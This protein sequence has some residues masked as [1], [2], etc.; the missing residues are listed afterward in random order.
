MYD[1]LLIVKRILPSL[2]IALFCTCSNTGP[3]R[4]LAVRG[5]IDLMQWDFSRSGSVDLRGEWE[6][7]WMRLLPPEDFT[8]TG[9]ADNPVYA[10]V[11]R[12]W[13]PGWK[14]YF[15]SYGR[16]YATYRLRIAVGDNLANE[17]GMLIERIPTACQLYVNSMLLFESGRVGTS[18][19]SVVPRYTESVVPLPR[20]DGIYDIVVHV[21]NYHAPA[22]GFPARIEIGKLSFLQKSLQT[23][24]LLSV[25]IVSVI[26]LLALYQVILFSFQRTELHYLYFTLICMCMIIYIIGLHCPFWGSVI[27]FL[28]WELVY[29]GMA[30]AVYLGCAL[31]VAYLQRLFPLD[32]PR[33]AVPLV[34]A[35]NGV[36]F[37]LMAL[38]PARWYA[39]LLPAMHLDL[40]MIITLCWFIIIRAALMRRE[41]VSYTVLGFMVLIISGTLDIISVAEIIPRTV[42]YLPCGIVFMCVLQTIGM[43]RDFILIQQRSRHLAV[44]N[45]KL[46]TMLAG[47]MRAGQPVV[48]GEIE[49]KINAAVGYLRENFAEDISRENLAATLDLH[50]DSF[51]RYFRMHTGK[52][53]SEFLNDLRV[54]EAVR[55]LTGTDQ[56]VITIAMNVGFNSLRTF[57]HAFMAATGKKP[58]DFRRQT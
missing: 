6:F 44:D 11:P 7:Y 48:T 15:P 28:R 5:H 52:K 56:P 54:V 8:G 4:P 25:F 24:D 33:Y 42:E 12:R 57:N 50:P 29:K 3:Q 53:Y 43:S 45:E 58:S 41:F 18:P 10:R 40:I 20:A 36:L 55:L 47:R 19:G 34:F 35:V 13:N 31:T 49:N 46:R 2:M 39:Y 38:L 1:I 17:M 51:S 14:V 30:M 37:A 21:A 32:A 26:F 27:P 9:S 16:G 22:G 23:K